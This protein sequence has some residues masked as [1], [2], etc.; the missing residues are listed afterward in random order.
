MS[1]L[2]GLVEDVLRDPRLPDAENERIYGKCANPHGHGHNY[3]LEVCVAG[4]VDPR[5]GRIVDPDWLDAL[6]RERA[7]ERLSHSLLNDDPAFRERVPTAEHIAQLVEAE[8]AGP[9]AAQG[10]RLVGVR[11]IETRRNV[12]ETGDPT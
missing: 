7:V 3:G 9:I 8:L 12:F 4:R 6:V 2:E 5:S 10:A 11:V 1:K